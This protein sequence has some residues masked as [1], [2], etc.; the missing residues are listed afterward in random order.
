MVQNKNPAVKKSTVSRQ[1]Y[2]RNNFQAHARVQQLRSKQDIS[3]YAN[4]LKNSSLTHRDLLSPNDCYQMFKEFMN[5]IM[6]CHNIQDQIE[7]II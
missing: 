6:K 1:E 2:V 3:T 4:V 5:A 7:N